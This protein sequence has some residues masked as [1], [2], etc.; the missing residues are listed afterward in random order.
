MTVNQD[1]NEETMHCKADQQYYV[2]RNPKL[3]EEF[4]DRPPYWKPIHIN[5]FGEIFVFNILREAHESSD[6]SG[7]APQKYYPAH[8]ADKFPPYTCF[9]NC[10][11]SKVYRLGFTCANPAPVHLSVNERR[12]DLKYNSIQ[13]NSTLINDECE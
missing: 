3:L 8:C 10:A 4:G 13:R 6:Q 2:I 1:A 12:N 9:L 11:W 7:S 5:R